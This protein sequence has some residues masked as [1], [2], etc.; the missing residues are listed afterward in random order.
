MSGP[1]YRFLVEKRPNLRRGWGWGVAPSLPPFVENSEGKEGMKRRL[2]EGI[3]GVYS[4]S[5]TGALSG[6]WDG[7]WEIFHFHF[8][9]D[10]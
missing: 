10:E 6:V 5:P 3:A 2:G 4:D 8:A 9:T 1:I 7:R